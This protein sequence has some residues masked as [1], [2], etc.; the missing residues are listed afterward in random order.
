MPLLDFK[1]RA[2]GHRFE[3]LVS[4]N[5]EGE[6]ACPKCGSRE[7]ARVYEGPCAFGASCGKGQG[8]GGCSGSCAHCKG[9]SH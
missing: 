2:C 5:H 7:L 4:L 6:V 1:C 3:E 8:A 9:C